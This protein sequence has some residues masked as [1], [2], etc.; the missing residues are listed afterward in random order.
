[1]FVNRFIFEP[2]G[3]GMSNTMNSR[4]GLIKGYAGGG[5]VR[6]GTGV[7]DD[8]PAFLSS[9]EYVVRKDVAKQ[10]GM[11]SFLRAM[12]EGSLLKAAAGSQVGRV[13][14]ANRTAWEVSGGNLEDGWD[15]EGYRT[16]IGNL[17]GRALDSDNPQNALRLERERA[18]FQH[19]NTRAQQLET[20]AQEY[21]DYVLQKKANL[22][23]A[24]ITA[25]ISLAAGHI[26]DEDMWGSE[27]GG[28]ETAG[29][30]FWR[31]LRR[32]GGRFANWASGL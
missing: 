6:G 22:R 10:P 8:V 13:S 16:E 14:E 25:G 2:I 21:K 27:W 9:G 3:A 7:R 20:Y 19:E 11:Y 17:T 15:L 5:K 12:N 24:L 31:G 29:G 26:M 30:R 23:G 4:G 32:S 1:M 28:P 18:V